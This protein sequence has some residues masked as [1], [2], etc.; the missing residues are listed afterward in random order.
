[1]LLS[2]S[3]LQFQKVLLHFMI[4]YKK[5]VHAYIAGLVQCTQ[6][7][8]LVIY[9]RVT[10]SVKG[11]Y[12]LYVKVREP[13]Q[14]AACVSRGGC[15]HLVPL[16]LIISLHYYQIMVLFCSYLSVLVAAVL[17]AT[18]PCIENR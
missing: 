5:H 7:L 18:V 9:G 2:A 6:L 13:K 8:P 3:G 14:W 15:F 11:N 1:M 10:R 16:K 4:A 17:A 12:T